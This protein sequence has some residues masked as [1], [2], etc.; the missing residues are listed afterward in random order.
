MKILI[1]IILTCSANIALAKQVPLNTE[2]SKVTWVG[3]KALPGGDEHT[4]TVKVQKGTINL[5]QNGTLVG[6]TIVIDMTSIECT[7]LSGNYKKKL[8]SHLKS[9]DFFLTDKHKQA[10]FKI[11]KVQSTRSNLYSVTGNLTI[12]GETHPE[13]FDVIV[14]EETDK[15]GKFLAAKGTISINRHKYGV[16]YNSETSVLR[17]LVKIAKDKIIKDDVSLTLD[18][19]TLTLK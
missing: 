11:T 7:D 12:R 6:G 8:E 4:G 19:Q 16:T 14:T 10:T 18:L 15:K 17:K 13:T 1:L 9:E 2:S 5:G 3:A